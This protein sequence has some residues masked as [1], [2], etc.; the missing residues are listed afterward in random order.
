MATRKRSATQAVKDEW[1]LKFIERMKTVHKRNIAPK[2]KRMLK[3]LTGV[4]NSMVTR[5]KKYEVECTITVDELREL[6]LEAYGTP[7]RYSQRILTISNMVFDH[8][9]PISKGGTSSKDN[10]QVIS[11]FA[12][13]VKGSMMEEDFIVLMEWLTSVPFGQDIAVRLAGGIR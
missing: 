11:K 12:N 10:I 6:A 4:K 2:A 7:C 1:E 5:S 3:R 13:S 8:K 9:V